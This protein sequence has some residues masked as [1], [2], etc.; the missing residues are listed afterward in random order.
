MKRTASKPTTLRPPRGHLVD[1][2]DLELSRGATS[3]TLSGPLFF[4]FQTARAL[5][6][7]L[8]PLG[9]VCAAHFIECCEREHNNEASARKASGPQDSVVTFVLLANGYNVRGE[10]RRVALT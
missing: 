2:A 3:L 4:L 9:E 8:C 6:W 5:C 10:H 7:L 1:Q